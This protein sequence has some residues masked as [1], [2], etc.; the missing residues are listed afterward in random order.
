MKLVVVF[1]PY[2]RN[3]LFL[4]LPLLLE[5][6]PLIVCLK[7]TF[8]AFLCLSTYMYEEVD[9]L[10]LVQVPLVSASARHFVVCTISYKSVVGFLPTFM[11]I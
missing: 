7:R 11:D 3:F 2:A 9:I 10:I 1:W 8:L 6:Y 5:S 4:A